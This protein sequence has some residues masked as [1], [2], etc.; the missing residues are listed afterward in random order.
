MHHAIY[1][2]RRMIAYINQLSDLKYLKNA[3]QL[4]FNRQ[5]YDSLISEKFSAQK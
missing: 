1:S 2:T 5:N 4:V 3:C